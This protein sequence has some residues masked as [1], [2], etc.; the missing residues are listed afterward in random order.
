[1]IKSWGG[2]Q[3]LSEN[4]RQI[5]L[6]YWFVS[7]DL[8]GFHL[9]LTG[10]RNHVHTS[11]LLNVVVQSVL[12]Q[13]ASPRASHSSSLSIIRFLNYNTIFKK[14]FSVSLTPNLLGFFFNMFSQIYTWHIFW[15]SSNYRIKFLLNNVNN[16]NGVYKLYYT[17]WF[18]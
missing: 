10:R 1:M 12:R 14:S 7:A 2:F 3:K 9:Q 18:V 16:V 8:V 5:W 17:L 11:Q 6:P 15:R 13:V 4:V